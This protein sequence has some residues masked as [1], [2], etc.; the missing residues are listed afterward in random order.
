MRNRAV[1][2]V[3]LLLAVAAAGCS[4]PD[5]QLSKATSVVFVGDSLA[6]ETAPFLESLLG[7]RPM[8]ADVQ[9]GTAPCDFF[10]L[11]LQI[12]KDSVVVISFTGNS[13]TPCM[14]DG[15]GGYLAGQQLLDKYRTDVSALIKQAR[16]ATFA[17]VLVG[18]PVRSD[19]WPT[20]LVAGL[21]KLYR[22]LAAASGVVFVDAGAAVEN[23]DGTFAPVL[24]CLPGEVEC[25]DSGT[26][27]VRTN[28][29]VHLCPGDL[30]IGP[31]PGY[32]SGAYRFAKAIADAINA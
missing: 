24:P 12:A 30:V 21:N 13:L 6:Q 17:V 29:G 9:P 5:P 4:K 28:D 16:A 8:V 1:A 7:G 2:S 20:D 31:C 15:A 27:I 26:N 11:D 10:N 22:D 18:Q 14:E 3:C 32:A 25:S 19:A 23:P